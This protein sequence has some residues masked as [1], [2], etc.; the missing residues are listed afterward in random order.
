MKTEKAEIIA[1]WGEGTQ[2]GEC[3]LRQ[4]LERTPTYPD[5]RMLYGTLAPNPP[6][7]H[8][9]GDESGGGGSGQHLHERHS[10]VGGDLRIAQHHRAVCHFRCRVHPITSTSLHWRDGVYH[11]AEC[12]VRRRV[13]SISTVCHVRCR[14][15]SIARVQ[16]SRW[17][18]FDV[19]S[20]IVFSLHLT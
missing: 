18:P 9:P 7:L 19:V 6:T 11:R 20:E 14:V 5:R 4:S 3:Q 17:K 10:P 8:H 15:P 1:G 13:R 12:H 2:T 16:S